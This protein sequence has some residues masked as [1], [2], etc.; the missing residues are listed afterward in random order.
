MS[1][2]TPRATVAAPATRPLVRQSPDM[3][4]PDT[5]R[6]A[7]ESAG[8]EMV[9]GTRWLNRVGALIVLLA[10]GFFVKYSFDQGW[11]S[12]ALRCLLGAAAGILAVAIGEL[13]LCR[14]MRHFAMGLLGLGI[15][16]LYL[17]VFGAQSFYGLLSINAAFACYCAV[18]ALALVIAVQA[19]SLPVA[20]IA[21]AGGYLTPVLLRTGQ[22]AQVALMT[23]L[24]FL[25][26][27]FLLVG[28]VRRWEVIRLLAAAGTAALFLAWAMEFYRPEVFWR[29]AGFVVAFYVLFQGESVLSLRWPRTW[30]I[31]VTPRFCRANTAVV[32]MLLAHWASSQYH[33]WLGLFTLA[34][35][36]VQAAIAL[37]MRPHVDRAVQARTSFWVDAAVLFGL[38][39]PVQFDG[40]STVIAWGVQALAGLIAARYVKQRWLRVASPVLFILILSHLCL[41]EFRDEALRAAWAGDDL[42]RI[43][44]LIALSAA[45]GLGAYLGCAG[46]AFRRELDRNDKAA[47]AAVAVIGSAIM[48]ATFSHEFDP[49][50][51]TWAWLVLAGAWLAAGQRFDALRIGALALVGASAIK[52]L[53]SDLIDA[54]VQGTWTDLPGFFFNREVLAGAAIAAALCV[55]LAQTYRLPAWAVADRNRGPLRDVLMVAVASV[56][57]I[58]GTFEIVRGFGFE[59]FRLRFHDPR[60]AMHLFLSILWS[61][62]A[63]VSLIIGFARRK[64]ILRYFSMLVFGVAVVKVL[65]VDISHLGMIYRVLSF[66]VVGLLLIVASLL[67]QKLASRVLPRGRLESVSGPEAR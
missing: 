46:L 37:T 34:A 35:A 41:Y 26:A 19:R 11:L 32:Y 44:P 60:R 61:T 62:A 38:A 21:L 67:Y 63:L 65:M 14:G 66:L 25:D 3:R 49:F 30:P 8:V 5:R 45:L 36:L 22:D 20:V 43:S 17:S 59:P 23:Y 13:S 7:P 40:P 4:P 54:V 18:T 51:A 57:I 53:G 28:A 64:T 12:P 39:A 24:L 55:C 6:D 29:T 52:F 10:V 16:L 15:G 50:A 1:M 58:V 33:D 9:I 47:I 42:W 31:D 48:L 56:L 2:P 27:G